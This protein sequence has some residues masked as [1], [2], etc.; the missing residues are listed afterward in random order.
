MSTPE[1]IAEAFARGLMGGLLAGGKAK[2]KAER[3]AVVPVDQVKAA[4]ADF[5]RPL[6]EEE[7]P[8]G[9]QLDLFTRNIENEPI[10]EMGDMIARRV[11]EARQRVEERESTDIPEGYFDPNAPQSSPWTSPKPQ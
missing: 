10:D 9:P 6:I 3:P 11:A 1:S 8:S 4:V 5:L 2:E 7:T